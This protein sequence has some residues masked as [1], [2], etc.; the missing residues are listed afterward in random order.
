[1]RKIKSLLFSLVIAVVMIFGGF[2]V[3]MPVADASN[4]QLNYNEYSE[5][6]QTI[7]G[8]FC[9]FRER[10][11]GSKVEKDAGT[12]IRDYLLTNATKVTAKI[13]DNDVNAALDLYEIL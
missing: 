6:V 9:V 12:Y 3:K 11:A 8:E 7:L 10:T 4:F 2:A 1:M 5:K 13:N